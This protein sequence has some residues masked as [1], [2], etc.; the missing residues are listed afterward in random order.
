MDYK[1]I[2]ACLGAALLAGFIHGALGM[3]FGMI[4]MAVVTLFMPFNNASA[5]VAVALLVLVSQ[6]SIVL[7][8]YIDW[9]HILL[10]SAALTIGKIIGI[11]LMMKLQTPFLRMA[12]G[13][14]LIIYS[15]SQLMNLNMSK[16]V[17]ADAHGII[18]CGLGGLFGGVFNVS[19]PFASIYCQ[20]KYGDDPKAYAANMNM[21]FVPSAV[22]ALIMH[23]CYGNFTPACLIGS[24]I[25]VL[26][27]LIATCF[28]VAVLKK[29]NV[30]NLRLISYTYIIIMGIVICVFG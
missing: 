2:A 15:A 11:V 10:P 28:G 7:R 16:I 30:K 24:G 5:I 26:G 4:A 22:V 13:I 1:I 3:G 14:F 17:R 27:V 25:M 21:I 6:V 20:E 23:I 9:R 8:K 12:L 18:T 29:L 19:G